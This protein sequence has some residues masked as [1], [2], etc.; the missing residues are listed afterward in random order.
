MS[1]IFKIPGR[2]NITL[3]TFDTNSDVTVKK[4]KVNQM[5]DILQIDVA[6]LSP[7][8]D[9]TNQNTRKKYEVFVTGGLGLNPIT[10][11]IFQTVFDQDHTFQTSNELLDITIGSWFSGSTVQ[12]TKIGD[13]SSGK[14][15]FPSSSLMMREK[16]DMYR[17]YAKN[18]L[19]DAEGCFISPFHESPSSTT[20]E[21][22]FRI[23]DA[24]FINFK[25]LFTRDRLYK[26]QFLMR[27]HQTASL[28]AGEANISSVPSGDLHYF[29]DISN[30]DL[31]NLGNTVGVGNY[32]NL[33]NEAGSPVGLIYYDK[34]IL[35][36]DASRIFVPTQKITGS[37]ETVGSIEEE[38]SAS[39][40]P[41]FWS[42]GSIDQIVDHICESRFDRDNS[43]SIVYLNQTD[44][45][46]TTYYC[47]VN[48]NE[49]NFSTNPTYTD[50]TGNFNVIEEAGDDP[51]SYIT[52]IGLYDSANNLV[53]VAKLSRPIEKNPETDLTISVRLDF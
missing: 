28:T 48:P 34:G 50:S 43:S 17:H 33:Y 10:S 45:N 31:V 32:S 53:A 42:S 39:F 24:I 16:I 14:I 21:N 27:M 47:R 19:H 1:D 44:I 22:K 18:L 20:F 40:I 30:S 7:S 13:D 9:N 4:S 29:A 25:R 38:I 35:V 2:S 15:L 23:E 26:K 8:P 52:S 51:F 6:G 46:T 12:D 41:D 3:K 5:I 37:I 36:L 49:Y 11:S